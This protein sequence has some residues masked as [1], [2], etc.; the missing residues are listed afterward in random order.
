MNTKCLIF[1]IIL[2]LTTLS[3]CYKK[4]TVN[5]NLANYQEEDIVPT[6]ANIEILG[7]AADFAVL[8]GASITSTGETT[9]TGSMGVYPGTLISG[10]INL[11]QGK[12]LSV[13]KTITAQDDALLAYNNLSE[14]AETKNMQWVNLGGLTLLPGVYSFN[15]S[16]ALTGIL[17]LDAED[18]SD[19]RWVFQVR[20]TLTVATSSK[21]LMINKGSALNV[22]WLIGSSATILA[23][24]E[25]LGNILVSSS[26]TFNHLATLKGRV[27]TRIGSITMDA[28]TIDLS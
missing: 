5:T 17:T 2:I 3:Y 20:S 16:A 25:M 13:D 6:E 26:I 24:C 1:V 8:G 11:V 21:V 23:N 27:L 4:L 10:K 28:N 9:V 12:R 7:T 19:A 18:D 22:Y 14:L 15:S